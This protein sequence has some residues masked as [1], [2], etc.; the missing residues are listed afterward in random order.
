MKA[1]NCTLKGFVCQI[2]EPVCV[3]RTDGQAR[4]LRFFHY[5]RTPLLQRNVEFQRGFV[6]PFE[7]AKAIPRALGVD[8]LFHFPGLGPRP[9]YHEEG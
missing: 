6:A 7:G 1:T 5:S 3:L 2:Y 4:Q 8:S 9:F